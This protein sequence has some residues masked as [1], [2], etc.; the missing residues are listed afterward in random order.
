MFSWLKRLLDAIRSLFVSKPPVAAP[1]IIGGNTV[2][3]TFTGEKYALLVGI[4][5]YLEPGN[6]LQ[7]CVND[8][9]DMAELLT[10]QYG[11]KQDN[12]RILTDARATQ[13]NIIERVEWL[14]SDTKPGDVLFWHQSSHGSQVRCRNGDELDD[15]MDEIIVPYDMDWDNPFTDDMIAEYFKRVPEGSSMTFCL[16][17][18]HSGSA[19]RGMT[20]NPHYKKAKFLP[21]PPD[22]AWRGQ[23]RD[24]KVKKFGT[25]GYRSKD[26]GN[27]HITTLRDVL[28]SGCRDNQTSADA[29]F[30][31]RYNGALTYYLLKA[32]RSNPSSWRQA[33]AAVLPGLVSGGYDQ[34]SQ[35]SGSSV[36]I[37]K[38]PFTV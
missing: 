37:D 5:K 17:A 33:H 11:F 9:M 2:A 34:V 32:L 28:I 15:G 12:I 13:A 38:A 1:A 8:V 22:V 23:G 29:Y 26:S 6:D 35:L 19:N 7:G 16:D 4:N 21:P 36:N 24:L 3:N 30:D 27:V 14:L 18:C 31:G 20:N 25:K 10:T